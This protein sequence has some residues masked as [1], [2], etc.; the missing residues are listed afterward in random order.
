[1]THIKFCGIT[2]AEDA[3]QAVDLGVNALGFN[4]WPGS[5]RFVDSEIAKDIIKNLPILVQSVGI[6]VNQSALDIKAIY[7]Q[8]GLNILQLHGDETPEF[9]RN[10]PK[11]PL[12]RAFR[13]LAIK[14]ALDEWKKL[15]TTFLVD[16]GAESI[17]IIDEIYERL[18]ASEKNN[19]TYGGS[20]KTAD[21]KLIEFFAP[22]GRFILAGGLTPANV[23][24]RIRKFRPF[25]VDV[26]SGIE[27]APGI[28]DPAKMRDFVA[29]VRAADHALLR[30]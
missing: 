2:R 27:S 18:S 21:K 12:I 26:A 16:G 17:V 13:H 11:I 29:A 22:H 30:P 8:C 6:F 1:M 9:A 28:K 15:R 5:K 10:L 23:G 20:G 25:A 3:V 4:F 19:L 14:H 7:D 24:E